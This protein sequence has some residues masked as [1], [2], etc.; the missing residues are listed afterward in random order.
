MHGLEAEFLLAGH[1]PDDRG[2]RF[3]SRQGLGIF[4]FTPRVKTG[5]GAHPASY[6]MGT[7]GFFPTVKAV[8][9]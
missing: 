1:G 3:R 5:S 7:R 4:L 9:A 6:T 2:S 8:G